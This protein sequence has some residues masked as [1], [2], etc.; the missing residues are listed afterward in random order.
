MAVERAEL[1]DELRAVLAAHKEL[2][3]EDDDLLIDLFLDRLDRDY[4]LQR[5]GRRRVPQR[6]TSTG[7][8]PP[9]IVCATFLVGLPLIYLAA[10]LWRE[11][12]GLVVWAAVVLTIVISLRLSRFLAEHRTWYHQ[13]LGRRA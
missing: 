9:E 1:R 11:L 5:R 7:A 6:R 13:Q 3:A 12:G 2:P 10:E 8:S 4:G